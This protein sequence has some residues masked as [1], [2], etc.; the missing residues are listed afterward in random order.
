MEGVIAGGEL[1]A[2]S[3]WAQNNYLCSCSSYFYDCEFWK[4]V[5]DQY[6]KTRRREKKSLFNPYIKDLQKY[7]KYFLQY[8]FY[9]PYSTHYLHE[10][11]SYERS[12]YTSI[13]NISH[14]KF[15]VDESKYVER[16][17][18]L[19]LSNKFDMK[20]IHLVR[21]GRAFLDSL[22]RAVQRGT[23][24]KK[25][26]IILEVLKWKTNISIQNKFLKNVGYKNKIKLSY[27]YLTKN[28]E[29][30]L[31]ELCAF[32]HID[33]NYSLLNPESSHYFFAH[34]HHLIG[35]NRIKFAHRDTKIIYYDDW[36]KNLSAW[37]KICF[38][39]LGGN[40]MNTMLSTK[41]TDVRS[42]R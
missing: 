27:E 7:K 23:R 29:L 3:K 33:Y 34:P 12:L 31:K 8:F 15:V 38:H 35:G 30:T 42:I 21:D 14:N 41:E 32:L 16:A 10:Y 28:T 19:Y 24:Q 5:F 4:E 6:C 36:K 20:F 40:K 17:L 25:V 26:N 22:K 37:E 13:L 11:S 2:F 9:I 18:K 1:W 39:F